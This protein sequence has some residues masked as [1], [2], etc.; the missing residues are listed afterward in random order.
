MPWSLPPKVLS[1]NTVTMEIKF[2]QEF[3]REHIRITAFVQTQSMEWRQN[4]VI[5]QR[6][7]SAIYNRQSLMALEMIYNDTVDSYVE[8]TP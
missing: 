5:V 7:G 4:Y 1:L 6:Q 2:H 8:T 3:W